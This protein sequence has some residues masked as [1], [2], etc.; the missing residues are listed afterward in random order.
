MKFQ[1]S[2][3]FS[4]SIQQRASIENLRKDQDD[5]S[6]T[7]SVSSSSS[8]SS[9]KYS[10]DTRSTFTTPR[11]DSSVSD[12]K[13][14]QIL[15]EEWCCFCEEPLSNIF[16]GE[17]LVDLSCG[18]HSHLECC[19]E[20]LSFNMTH[21]ISDYGDLSEGSNIFCPL[22][23][24]ANVWKDEYTRDE[25][26]KSQLLHSQ[27]NILFED[28][29]LEK[30]PSITISQFVN[31]PLV[32]TSTPIDPL[33]PSE[34]IG[35]ESEAYKAQLKLSVPKRFCD[36][37]S[38]GESPTSKRLPLRENSP[39]VSTFPSSSLAGKADSTITPH[40]S[41][42]FD[43]LFGAKA[44]MVPEYSKIIFPSE[45]SIGEHY[46]LSCVLN[47]K[48]SDYEPSLS[49]LPEN[50]YSEILESK[51]QITKELIQGFER[52][53]DNKKD[54]D[55]ANLGELILFDYMQS[56]SVGS[57]SYELCQAFLFENC[58]L[59]LDGFGNKVLQSIDI[60]KQ[61]SSVF[62]DPK[63]EL[64]TISLASLKLHEIIMSSENK[65]IQNKWV[66]QLTRV[67]KEKKRVNS[68]VS[69][70]SLSDSISSIHSIGSPYSS[71][72][73]QSFQS[74]AKNVPLIQM[75]T[76]AW[77][78]LAHNESL[79]PPDVLKFSKLVSKG[80]DLP[81]EFMK[82]QITRPDATPLSLILAIPVVNS[83]DYYL[84]DEEFTSEIKNFVS[85]V[86]KSL[87]PEDKLGLV[88]VGNKPESSRL[89]NYYGCA[90]SSWENWE[91]IIDS[92]ECYTPEGDEEYL[93]SAWENALKYI[94]L[95]SVTCFGVEDAINHA[96]S[97]RAVVLV[98]TN[99]MEDL[100]NTEEIRLKDN[101]DVPH[102]KEQNS[103]VSRMATKICKDYS[104]QFHSVL[105]ADEYRY[106]P[107]ELVSHFKAITCSQN[108][109]SP[110]L[111]IKQHLALEFDHLNELLIKLIDKFHNVTVSKLTST[112]KMAKGVELIQFEGE[113][114]A[115]SNNS[116]SD[117]LNIEYNNIEIGFNRSLMLKLRINLR[118]IPLSSIKE[119]CIIDLLENTTS[120]QSTWSP[121]LKKETTTVCKET[122]SIKLS[123]NRSN[124]IS[125]T[126]PLSF[127]I[128]N[129][130]KDSAEEL[131]LS[132]L[133]RLSAVKDAAFVERKI[134][135]LIIDA[136][137]KE[138][139]S[140]SNFT[141][142]VKDKI[143]AS[144]NNLSTEIWNLVKS[145]NNSNTSNITKHNIKSWSEEL[146]DLLSEV[147]DGY[148]MRNYHLS[149]YM[150]VAKYFELL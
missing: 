34:Q 86:L 76:N 143:K 120:I 44:E 79:I 52:N 97:I 101:T 93:S 133:P 95:L 112:L 141:H 75:S 57:S 134:E 32:A 28:M 56:V 89:G 9:Y 144:L 67:L 119:G 149:N 72:N 139:L 147:A 108:A 118:L 62:G 39:M 90:T 128:S 98:S 35:M 92:I 14:T 136:F 70:K 49:S 6:E 84:D 11:Q 33:T 42:N 12:R 85:N 36:A 7:T 45:S 51:L 100:H 102:T 96:K 135:M 125:S 38:L 27:P 107:S 109:D 106:S 123:I 46:D 78:L 63:D 22:C 99:I 150:A 130:E 121:P 5:I 132:I 104:A 17:S 113:E 43:S 8:S 80:L 65:V 103:S 48:S 1:S 148:S 74:I 55:V 64:I 117:V 59:I 110:Q 83:A 61:F 138:I 58:L 21:S 54:L 53:I 126:Q 146:I 91:Q 26:I 140:E 2:E 29:F 87:N 66:K 77:G 82:R 142:V 88:F 50:K 24:V 60:K 30:S 47:I 31:T 40:F 19:T 122:F 16:E 10:S 127:L 68:V 81:T 15:S 37:T 124:S 111:N 13:K 23:G 115:S 69:A 25:I 129:Q 4:N 3:D 145:C 18:H 114:R 105:L 94:Q 41:F 20:L 73:N 71:F 137:K 116:T 131:E